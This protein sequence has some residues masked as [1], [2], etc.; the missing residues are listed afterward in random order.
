MLNSLPYF[1]AV[2]IN[3]KYI[4]SYQTEICNLLTKKRPPRGGAVEKT[5]IEGAYFGSF[6]PRPCAEGVRV[7]QIG[8]MCLFFISIRSSRAGGVWNGNILC[9]VLVISIHSSRAGG[10][11][12]AAAL[13]AFSHHISI[14]SS[15]TSGVG[16]P[17]R[18]RSNRSNFN[19]L[20][21][22]GRSPPNKT[23]VAVALIFQSTPLARV[24]SLSGT[25]RSTGRDH[26]NPLL[27]HGRSPLRSPIRLSSRYFNPLLPKSTSNASALIFQSTPLAREES[28]AQ[29][30]NGCR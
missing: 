19:P 15:R 20:L 4:I 18:R 29:R 3:S 25:G 21:P 16:M 14:H 7:L 13:H 9:G 24:E 23:S 2:R 30:D 22:C 11:S 5:I 6:N 1:Q 17:G 26:F 28:E 12:D 8:G 10:V 27:L